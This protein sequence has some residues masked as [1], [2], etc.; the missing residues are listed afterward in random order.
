MKDR[1]AAFQELLGYRFANLRL[2][3]EALTHASAKGEGAPSYERLEFFGDAV[4]GLVISE[5]L[6]HR[7]PE[8]NEGDLTGKK[9]DLVSHPALVRL[10]RDMQIARFLTIGKGLPKK[11]L[12]PSIAADAVEA[13]IG[14]VYLDGG[15]MA[16]RQ[17]VLRLY[18]DHL[19]EA[20]RGGENA[21]SRLQE[22]TQ[23][24]FGEA[25]TYAVLD[26]E[27]PDHRKTFR[28][29]CGIST[30]E[31][32]RGSGRT[33]KEAEQDAAAAALA[34]LDAGPRHSLPAHD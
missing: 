11:A 2:L 13:V 17:L 5:A 27:G 30:R 25:P 19:S 1:L 33:K 7:F 15:L 4:L 6:F 12:P 28:V 34:R 23:K 18:G 3:G 22:V 24:R 26:A 29:S 8:D 21:K 10:A 32:G 20:A 31:L 14:A 16:A 9:S